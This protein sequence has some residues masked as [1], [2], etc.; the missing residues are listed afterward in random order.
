M[1]TFLGCSL[2]WLRITGLLNVLCPTLLLCGEKP[3]ENEHLAE[4]TSWFQEG[5]C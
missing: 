5:V 4:E 2:A 1:G 3:N